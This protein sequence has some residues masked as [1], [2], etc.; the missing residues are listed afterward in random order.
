MTSDEPIGLEPARAASPLAIPLLVGL[1][2]FLAGIALTLAIV[3]MGGGGTTAKL[4]APSPAPTPAQPR[5]ALVQVPPGTDIATLYAREQAL[6]ARLDQLDQRLRDVDNGA[7]TA[8]GHATQAERLLIAVA[9]RRAVE[10]GQPLG[11]LELQLRQRFGES[12]ADAVGTIV[13]AAGQPLTLEDLRLALDALGPRLLVAP[14]ET[15][16]G[17]ARRLIGDLVVLRRQDSP[18]PRGTDRLKRAQRMLDEGQVEAALAEVIHLPG[19]GSGESW[20]TAARRYIG[21]RA[22]LREIELAAMETPPAAPAN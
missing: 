12:H 17:G 7:R 2:A 20:V 6:A 10:R 14:G 13:Q 22:A 15:W 4:V 5:P 11:P 18:S 3:F 19:A 1:I 9:V 8:A 16:W 21:A